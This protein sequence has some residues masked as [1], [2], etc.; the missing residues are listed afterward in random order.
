MT[1]HYT[2][3]AA[4]ALSAA[5]VALPVVGQQVQSPAPGTPGAGKG[6]AP[7][8]AKASTARRSQLY[9][10]EMFTPQERQAFFDQMKAAK[11]PEERTK[12][13]AERRATAEA[14]AKDKGITLA[15]PPAPAPKSR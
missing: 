13:Q 5:V 14:R 3:A 10:D 15:A 7:D 4:I 2:L 8:P 6:P 9:G 12:L 11:T 1:P